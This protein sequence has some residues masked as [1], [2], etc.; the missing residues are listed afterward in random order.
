MPFSLYYFLN[1][2]RLMYMK[3][4]FTCI[5]Y[6]SYFP[7]ITIRSRS[8]FHSKHSNYFGTEVLPYTQA[9]SYKENSHFF[10]QTH[11]F[12][13]LVYRSRKTMLTPERKYICVI[14][15]SECYC[16]DKSKRKHLLVWTWRIHISSVSCLNMEL[17]MPILSMP[18][19]KLW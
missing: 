11:S 15:V 13:L 5:Y 4:K 8:S 18:M 1:I 9:M 10:L 16:L 19:L 17:N 2:N 6:E 3:F 7:H 14:P 12:I